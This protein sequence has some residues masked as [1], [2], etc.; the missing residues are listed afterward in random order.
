MLL[1][2]ICRVKRKVGG[3]FH[4]APLPRFRVAHKSP[5]FSHTL[6]AQ[7]FGSGLKT[8]LD[9]SICTQQRSKQ[10]FVGGFVFATSGPQSIIYELTEG[11]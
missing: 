3:K 4:R 7:D 11:Q 6:L 8:L 10:I 2:F 1:P 9:A 5:E